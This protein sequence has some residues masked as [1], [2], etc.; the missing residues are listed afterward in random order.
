MIG[1]LDASA[2]LAFLQGEP[3][4]DVVEQ[5]LRD[6]ATCTAVNWSEVAQ[7][8]RA[9]DRDWDLSRALLLSYQVR[10]EPVVIDDAEHAASMWRRGL[11]LSLADRVCLAVAARLGVPAV[12]ADGAWGAG[13]GIVQIR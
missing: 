2:I 4:A 10:V 13:P 7:K 3:G 6:G 12:T 1:V 11:G 5:H 9:A 8:V